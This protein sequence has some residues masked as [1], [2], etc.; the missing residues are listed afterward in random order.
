MID[1]FEVGAGGQEILMGAEQG[2]IRI[3]NEGVQTLNIQWF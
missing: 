2:Q 3:F 1:F